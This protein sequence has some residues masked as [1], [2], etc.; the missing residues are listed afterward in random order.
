MCLITDWDKP[1]TAKEDIEC[2]KWCIKVTDRGIFSPYMWVPMPEYNEIGY[3]DLDEPRIASS[4]EKRLYRDI[5]ANIRGKYKV[6]KGF[7]SFIREIDAKNVMDLK[8]S[9]R[10]EEPI[11]VSCIIPKGAMY[12]KGFFVHYESYCSDKIILEEEVCV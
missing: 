1:K 3:S 5:H 6:E 12:Y 8:Y 11:L 4:H 9:N 7:H 10:I 2:Y